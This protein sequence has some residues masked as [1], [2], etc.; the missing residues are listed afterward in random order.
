V[1]TAGIASMTAAFQRGDV[2]EAARQGALAGPAVVEKAL[3]SPVRAT[4]LAAIA[5]A[6]TVADRAELLPALAEVAAGP[7]RRVAIPAARAA[8]TIAGEL[9]RTASEHEL[10]DDLAPD[11]VETWRARFEAIAARH[12]RAVEVRLLALETCSALA[13]VIDP[14]ATGFDAKAFAADP[15][16]DIARQAADLA[17]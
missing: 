13:H 4:R 1:A 14:A 8:Q 9:S 11:D 12:G 15:D 3:H 6:P 16:P 10:P 17:R 5:A 2:D 7:D